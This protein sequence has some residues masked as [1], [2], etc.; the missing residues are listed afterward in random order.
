VDV[1][2]RFFGESEL[3][4]LGAVVAGRA[5]SVDSASRVR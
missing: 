3:G 2:A 4:E 1:Q 5:L